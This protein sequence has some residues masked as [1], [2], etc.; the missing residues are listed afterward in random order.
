MFNYCIH[1]FYIF[2]C[3][4][5]RPVSVSTIVFVVLTIYVIVKEDFD[6]FSIM[7]SR[8]PNV[9]KFAFTEFTIVSDRKWSAK[10]SHCSEK[11]METSITLTLTTLL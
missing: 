11:I 8:Q 5:V 10:C 2:G 6:F 7:A 1:I 4:N 9:C 3:S